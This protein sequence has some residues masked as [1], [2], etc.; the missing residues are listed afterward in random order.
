[1]ASGE[2]GTVGVEVEVELIGVG[3]APQVGTVEAG[4]EYEITGVE[5]TGDIGTVV[6]EFLIPLTGVGA[7]GSVGSVVYVREYGATLTG[8]SARGYADDVIKAP[9]EIGISGVSATGEVGSLGNTNWITIDDTQTPFWQNV[10]TSSPSPG[11]LPENTTPPG[12]GP[13]WT[14]T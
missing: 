3:S 10:T 6:P 1:M 14:P 9:R 13:G 2:V 4:I 5:A 12:P 7:E 8:V 11:W